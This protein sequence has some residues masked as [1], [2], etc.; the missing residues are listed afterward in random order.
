MFWV[1]VL[2][3]FAHPC[4]KKKVGSLQP[5]VGRQER[6]GKEKKKTQTV[7]KLIYKKK[8]EKAT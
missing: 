4:L 1:T 2:T 5:L 7:Y 3:L 6:N 8:K